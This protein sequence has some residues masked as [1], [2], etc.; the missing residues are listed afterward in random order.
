MYAP[1]TEVQHLLGRV[2]TPKEREAVEGA[3]V[4]VGETINQAINEAG[5]LAPIPPEDVLQTRALRNLQATG[6]V[7]VLDEAWRECFED[8][9][10]K[11][12]AG[13]LLPKYPNVAM[14]HEPGDGAPSG[15]VTAAEL[16]EEEE[17]KLKESLAELPEEVLD[18]LAEVNEE[19]D[20]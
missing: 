9:M 2:C 10:E 7:L 5:F 16:T 12:K 15:T 8:G 1:I 6:A 11:L 19:T 4:D 3:L 13:K 20:S 14:K 18:A 17:E